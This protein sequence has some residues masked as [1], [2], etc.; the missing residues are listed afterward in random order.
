MLAYV[1][2]KMWRMVCIMWRM[3]IGGIFFFNMRGNNNE[4]TSNGQN[5]WRGEKYC[6]LQNVVIYIFESSSDKRLYKIESTLYFLNRNETF[7]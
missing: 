1:D 5:H 2:R 4:K 3:V 7:R 6:R